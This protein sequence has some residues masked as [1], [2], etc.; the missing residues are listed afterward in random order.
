MIDIFSLCSISFKSA[1]V[2]NETVRESIFRNVIALNQIPQ[3]LQLSQKFSG[4]IACTPTSTSPYPHCPHRDYRTG[5]SRIAHLTT[6]S[7]N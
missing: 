5:Q 7:A 3:E 6:L 4:T 1:Q 2:L